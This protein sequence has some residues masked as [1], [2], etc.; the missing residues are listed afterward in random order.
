VVDNPMVQGTILKK[1]CKL[2]TEVSQKKLMLSKTN[3]NATYFP[4][5]VSMQNNI[6]MTKLRQKSDVKFDWNYA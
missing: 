2:G 5:S 3:K 1:L 4:S 6:V